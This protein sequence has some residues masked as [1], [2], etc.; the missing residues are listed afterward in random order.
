M[1]KIAVMGYGTV[2]SGVYQVINTNSA[3]VNKNANE[4]IEIKYVLDLRD[5]PGDP[6]ETVLTHNFED[7]V[8]DAEVSVVVEVMGGIRPAYDFTKACLERGKSVCTSNKEL[9]ALHGAELI[10]IAEEHGVTYLFEASV[11]GGIPI[12][13]TL[14]SSITSEHIL[15]I[16]GILNGTTNYMLTKMAKE[17]LEYKDVLKEAQEKGYAERNPAA[18]VEGHDACRKIAILMSLALEGQVD[19]RDVYT[20]GITNISKIDMEYAAAMGKEIKLLGVGKNSPEGISVMVA[21]FLV[22]E[23]SPL[24]SVRDVFNGICITG[25]MLGEVMFYGRGAGKEAT[26]AAVVSDVIDAV[27]NKI[28]PKRIKWACEKVELLPLEKISNSKLVR[29]EAYDEEAGEKAVKAVFGDVEI[30]RLSDRDE[31]AFVAPEESEEELDRKLGILLNNENIENIAGTI[32][33]EEK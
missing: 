25:N 19:Y 23:D 29:V 15:E 7:I 3:I 20:E 6:V 32:R 16:K 24:Y 18:D 10:K 28:N 8:N 21:P 4:E 13:R 31:F 30:I 22:G 2:G 12:I 1:A 9:V 26:A 14:I 5:F 33:I 27:R 17:G 11:G